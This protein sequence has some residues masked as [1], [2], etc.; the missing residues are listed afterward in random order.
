MVAAIYSFRDHS[1]LRRCFGLK[2]YT[3]G[4]PETS[5]LLPDREDAMGKKCEPVL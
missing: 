2:S 4:R 1:A 3:G 5:I